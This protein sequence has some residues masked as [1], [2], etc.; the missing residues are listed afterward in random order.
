MTPECAGR[1]REL[2]GTIVDEVHLVS[3]PESAE[4]SKLLENIFRG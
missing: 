3:S 2:Y 1:A 4:L